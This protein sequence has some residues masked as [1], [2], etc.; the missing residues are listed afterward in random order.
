MKADS[1]F[2]TFRS[3]SSSV[4]DGLSLYVSTVVLH[5]ELT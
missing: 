3:D 5:V 1:Y 2:E 4:L